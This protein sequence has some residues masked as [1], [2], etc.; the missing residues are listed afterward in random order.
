MLPPIS[1][2]SARGK[3]GA[4][5]SSPPAY[6]LRSSRRQAM[7]PFPNHLSR[8][9][10]R[11]EERLREQHMLDYSLQSASLDSE[12][13]HFSTAR[14]RRSLDSVG[15]DV[16]GLR[17]DTERARRTQ[18]DMIGSVDALNGQV[19]S[20]G[21]V[22]GVLADVH[23]ESV[24]AQM[25]ELKVAN[26]TLERRCDDLSN[27]LALER[28]HVA[29]LKHTLRGHIARSREQ[30]EELR[31]VV[32]QR[33]SAEALDLQ[34]MK[35]DLQYRCD[36]AAA[37]VSTNIVPSSA[38]TAA[39][40]AAA[41][42]IGAGSGGASPSASGT[43]QQQQ[44]QAGSARRGSPATGSRLGLGGSGAGDAGAGA[45]G[46]SGAPLVTAFDPRLTHLQ[47]GVEQANRLIEARFSQLRAELA[48]I[49]VSDECASA[50]SIHSNI[51]AVF[52]QALTQFSVDEFVTLADSLSFEPGVLSAI[53]SAVYAKR[54]AKLGSAKA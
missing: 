39:A 26:A 33:I 12:S 40:A 21:H 41:A 23:T 1:P 18:L 44:Q 30:V 6:S 22:L 54:G 29:A 49:R 38:T 14:F 37:A 42:F 52:R 16:R 20:L 47:E 25:L 24:K 15:G 31:D 13:L 17:A 50:L 7:L 5:S 34:G 9:I 53:S 8:A 48:A 3:P 28:A 4:S 11:D 19:Q 46:G 45:G 2:S 10:E 27:D 43:P 35:K 36:A 32:R 51:P